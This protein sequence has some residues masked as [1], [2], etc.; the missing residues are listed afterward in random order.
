MEKFIEELSLCT[1]NDPSMH[2]LEKDIIPIGLCSKD[3]G[4]KFI[5]RKGKGTI[6]NLK[7]AATKK[8]E[9]ELMATLLRRLGNSIIECILSSYLKVWK[10]NKCI[11]V[12]SVKTNKCI[13]MFRWFCQFFT[14]Q[15][16]VEVG[17]GCFFQ[18]HNSLLFNI[19]YNCSQSVGY[20]RFLS[21]FLVLLWN[22]SC[23]Q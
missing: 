12:K 18:C 11:N 22:T 9:K 15:L 20:I 16:S 23:T 1:K 19:I 6:P 14:E 2:L 7:P 5:W 3:H 21:I 8:E 10:T 17:V 13:N 4:K